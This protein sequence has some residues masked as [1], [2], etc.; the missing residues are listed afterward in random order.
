MVWNMCEWWIYWESYLVLTGVTQL[1][2]A[3]SSSSSTGVNHHSNDSSAALGS[4][5]HNQAVALVNVI[6]LNKP[7]GQTVHKN[8]NF[9]IK[10]NWVNI[11]THQEIPPL[12]TETRENKRKTHCAVIRLHK[13][14]IKCSVDDTSSKG[15]RAKS[16][17]LCK[18]THIYIYLYMWTCADTD[19]SPLPLGREWGSL[20]PGAGH[21]TSQK[22]FVL[23]FWE[24]H[25][26]VVYSRNLIVSD[27]PN[28]TNC[29]NYCLEREATTKANNKTKQ[30][31]TSEWVS[32]HRLH[33]KMCL[34]PGSCNLMLTA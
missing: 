4:G 23:T 14:N 32:P 33:I 34:Q 21:H 24:K 20:Q 12:H 25:S 13:L 31:Q 27:Q 15:N 19:T 30:K 8:A 11:F 6:T 1:T 5:R 16:K 3:G 17:A 10:V 18:Y 26:F 2:C 7:K 29:A 9:N 28:K 22:H